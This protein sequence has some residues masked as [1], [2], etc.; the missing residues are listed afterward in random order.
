MLPNDKWP[1]YPA[2][3]D[4]HNKLP[5]GPLPLSVVHHNYAKVL[6]GDPKEK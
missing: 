6:R 5:S 2:G 4:V 3:D 1:C